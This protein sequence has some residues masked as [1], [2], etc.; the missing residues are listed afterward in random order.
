MTFFQ[1]GFGKFI[2]LLTMP[3]HLKINESKQTIEHNY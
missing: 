3:K 1:K 2:F